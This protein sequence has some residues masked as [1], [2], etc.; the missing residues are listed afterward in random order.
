MML[1]CWYV[2]HYNLQCTTTRYGYIHQAILYFL[3]YEHAI[4]NFELYPGFGNRRSRQLIETY[5]NIQNI[6]SMPD[7]QNQALVNK[8]TISW[9]DLIVIYLIF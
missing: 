5:N 4:Y 7:L 1:L 8:V 6:F 2:V 9:Y 3:L